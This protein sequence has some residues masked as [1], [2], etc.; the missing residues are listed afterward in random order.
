MEHSRMF[1]IFKSSKN[2]EMEIL[3]RCPNLLNLHLQIHIDPFDS[4]CRRSVKLRNCNKENSRH[5]NSRLDHWPLRCGSQVHRYQICIWSILLS[6]FWVPFIIFWFCGKKSLES[7]AMHYVYWIRKRDLGGAGTHDCFRFNLEK[8]FE[9]L[10]ICA[11]RFRA[12]QIWRIEI[13]KS[14]ND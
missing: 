5:E 9:D 3:T 13:F 7:Q 14:A 6:L 11:A 2:K 1:S 10:Q 8:D 4:R 12:A